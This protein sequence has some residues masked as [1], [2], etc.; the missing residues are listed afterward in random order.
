MMLMQLYDQVEY[1]IEILTRKKKKKKKKE[2]TPTTGD[3][4]R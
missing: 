1:L 2:K 4:L 3:N